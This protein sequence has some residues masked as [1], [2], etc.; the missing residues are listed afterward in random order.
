MRGEISELHGR[1]QRAAQDR[2]TLE[3]ALA[4]TQLERLRLVQES[5]ERL[6]RQSNQYEERLTELHS[7]IAE[8]TRKLNRQQY[9]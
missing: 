6:E 5:E 2:D 8:L 7:V 4:K 1:L 9:K 3:Q